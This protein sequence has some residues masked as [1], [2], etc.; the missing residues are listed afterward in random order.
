MSYKKFLTAAGIMSAALIG[1]VSI[2]M[3]YIDPL[4][5]FRKPDLYRPQYLAAERYQM[6]GLLKNQDYD[7]L[8][9]A[10]SMGRNFRESFAN[11]K[12]GTKSFNGSLPAS[13]AKEQSMVAEAAFRDKPNLKRVIWELNYYSFAGDP[14][15]VAGPPSDFPTYMYDKSKIN[16]LRYLFSSYSVEILYKNL[17]ANKE[18]N[19]QR[20]EVET[21]YKF[22]QVAPVESIEHVDAFLKGVQPMDELPSYE[23]ASVQMESFKE[24]VIPLVKAHPNTKFTFFYA[25]YP[26]YNHVSFYKKNKEYLTER[27]KFKKEVFDLMHKYPNVEL[28]D[29]QDMHDITFN[30]DNYQGD[31][32]H[33][34]NFINNWIIDYLATHKPVQSE[35]EYVAKLQNFEHQITNFD[36]LQLK[37]VSSIKQQYAIE[38]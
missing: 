34:Y 2:V 13:T 8:F 9:T 32:V 22:G 16:D 36:V 26:I 18:G 30:I 7:T 4:F 10:T 38:N 15:W 25:P 5:Y 24:N 21:L 29:F 20:R 19:E 35:K 11:E 31:T 33:Y 17:M 23:R 14:D 37:K 6:P 3:Y 1:I 28:Y 12:L 27:L